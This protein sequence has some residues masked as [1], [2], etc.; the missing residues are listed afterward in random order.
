EILPLLLPAT[1][2]LAFAGE[3]LPYESCAALAGAF[4]RG[5]QLL[6]V[7]ASLVPPSPYYR[8]P[9]ETRARIVELAMADG[10]RRQRQHTK[11]A[12]SLTCRAFHIAVHPFSDTTV[13]L[14]TPRQL[15]RFDQRCCFE[16]NRRHRTWDNRRFK[17]PKHIRSLCI[18]L[19]VA[20]LEAA[21][22]KTAGTLLELLKGLRWLDKRD[23]R[24][25]HIK[26]RSIAR[27]DEE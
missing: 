20:D 23:L 25:L 6:A 26:F 21:G 13:A 1:D 4:A 5:V 11:F 15:E 27:L 8:L 2:K 24:T 9:A 16:G 22:S 7:P 18:D 14:Y 3:T 19:D 10:D 17:V 12:L